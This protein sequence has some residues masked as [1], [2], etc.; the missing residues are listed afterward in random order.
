MNA[1]TLGSLYMSQ[2]HQNL[3][4]TNCTV[5]SDNRLV[6]ITLTTGLGNKP[7]LDIPRAHMTEQRHRFARWGGQILTWM[8]VDNFPHVRQIQR[9]ERQTL[10]AAD[11]KAAADK[12]DIT[13]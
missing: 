6:K 7:G 9:K 3:T 8:Y 11:I 13:L 2:N 1:P 10:S 12:C 5:N 4:L